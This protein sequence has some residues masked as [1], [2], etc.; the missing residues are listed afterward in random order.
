MLP[1]RVGG[2][3]AAGSASR[4]GRDTKN[5]GAALRDQA[6]L[7]E[8]GE[9]RRL[10]GEAVEAYR[11]ALEVR[12]RREAPADWAGTQNNLGNALSAQAGLAEGGE[13]ARLLGKRWQAYRAALEVRTRRE[14]PAAWAMTQYNLAL[15]HRDR[16]AAFEE[17]D[18]NAAL[19][20]L[21][22]AYVCVISSLEVYTKEHMPAD[23]RDA[24]RVRDRIEAKIH[25]L[26]G[27][28]G[29]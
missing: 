10:L 12:T 25:A 26:G 5:L 29:K 11:A 28:P 24:I 1:C 17:E 7:A 6:G 13:R 14:A 19:R 9:R 20:A 3:H 2:L 21:Q 8:G 22:E 4:L 15:L 27:E 23:H 16:A 18:V